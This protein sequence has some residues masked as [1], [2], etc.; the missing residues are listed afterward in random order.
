MIA[1]AVKMG[2]T[3]KN[4]NFLIKV[5]ESRGLLRWGFS[6]EYL[7]M[8]ERISS[9]IGYSTLFFYK[10][11]LLGLKLFKTLYRQCLIKFI[12]RNIPIHFFQ[13]NEFYIYHWISIIVSMSTGNTETLTQHFI[14][15]FLQKKLD[16]WY[17]VVIHKLTNQQSK[18]SCKNNFNNR[19]PSYLWQKRLSK[20]WL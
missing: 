6:L 11:L 7:S 13:K 10:G 19:N 9:Y 2:L 20:I 5:W 3:V 17:I 16:I 8:S 18:E 4:V 1:S 14:L 15:R 12:H